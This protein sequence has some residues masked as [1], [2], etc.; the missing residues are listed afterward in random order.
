MSS[1]KYLVLFTLVCVVSLFQPSQCRLDYHFF[2]D[3]LSKYSFTLPFKMAEKTPKDWV[4]S[5]VKK[6]KVVVFS[7]SYCPYC[8]RAKDA[9]KKLNLHDLHVEELDSNPNMDQVQ[10][11]LNQLTGARSV[12]RVFVNGRFYGDSTKTVSDVESGKFMEHYKKT[13]L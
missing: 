7:K 8:T 9:L 12:P 11:Y 10:D 3:F 5:L 4:D 13:D 6:H 2:S 1:V